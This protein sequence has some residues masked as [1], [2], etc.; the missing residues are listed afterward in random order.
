MSNLLNNNTDT[1]RFTIFT[2]L[3]PERFKYLR[4]G[5]K[6][7][8]LG[9]IMGQWKDT[10]GRPYHYKIPDKSTTPQDTGL[11]IQPFT[12]TC[13]GCLRDTPLT[14]KILKLDFCDPSEREQELAELLK[15]YHIELIYNRL[16]ENRL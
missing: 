6:F 12:Y 2:R 16:P 14:Q 13:R 11:N 3:L 9:Q 10:R 8:Y 15:P 4:N 1:R 5:D 7:D